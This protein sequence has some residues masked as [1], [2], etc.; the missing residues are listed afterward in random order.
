MRG[1]VLPIRVGDV[2]IWVGWTSGEDLREIDSFLILRLSH[3][4]KALTSN[5]AAC[6]ESHGSTRGQAS[7][8][9]D[10][11]EPMTSR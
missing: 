4:D 10:D 7:S 8:K 11:N 1:A 2:F 3:Q 5:R 9:Y 6:G